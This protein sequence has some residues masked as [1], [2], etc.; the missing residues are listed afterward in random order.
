MGVFVRVERRR[1]RHTL[2]VVDLQVGGGRGQDGLGVGADH[3][4]QTRR[5]PGKGSALLHVQQKL[6]GAVGAGGEDDVVGGE[7]PATTTRPAST[8]PMRP[9]RVPASGTRADGVDGGQRNDRRSRL[10]GEIQVV[11]DQRVLRADRAA[12]HAG[13]AVGAAGTGRAGTAEVRVL[14]GLARLT[15]EDADRGVDERVADAHVLGD[16][17]DHPVGR[18]HLRV[19]G[20]AEHA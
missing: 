6:V 17:A 16:L 5:Q 3:L 7:R 9:D 8:R 15:E 20:H 19:G 12:G 14:D 11:L 2:G 10:L 4:A 13:A 18:R 1:D